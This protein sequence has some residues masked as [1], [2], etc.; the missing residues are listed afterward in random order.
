MR[1]PLRDLNKQHDP[2]QSELNEAFNSVL[3]SG[4]FIEGPQVAQFE[5]A[6]SSRLDRRFAVGVSCGTEALYLGLSALE[7]KRGDS[8]VVTSYS[9]TPSVSC[10]TRLGAHPIFVDIDPHTCNIDVHAAQRAI[11]AAEVMPRA[12]VVVHLFGQSVDMDAIMY[13]AEH[14]EIPVVED[15]AQALGAIY[16]SKY[17]LSQVGS[18]GTLACFSFFPTKPLGVL[19][20]GGM[21]LT[22]IEHVADEVRRLKRHGWDE[23]YVNNRSIGINS[24]LDE[25]QAAFLNVKLPYLDV[26]TEDVRRMAA[27]YIEELRVPGPYPQWGVGSNSWHIYN[28]QLPCMHDRDNM[29][30]RLDEAQ[31]GTEIYFP[32]SLPD[33]DVFGGEGYLYP[34]A[35]RAAQTL[36][37]IPL[38]PGMTDD[39]QS[40]VIER[41]NRESSCNT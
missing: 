15:C 9:L 3:N 25:V 16:P 17:G 31:I 35:N 8:V 18:M 19:G 41:V 32:R 12:I 36:L 10:I 29:K 30:K 20:D 34:N 26:W 39:Q 27:R 22:D 2:I 24:R 33:Q 4:T 13:L 28:L 38:F 23:K 5:H 11:E 37:A 21:V 6:I 1:V 14:Y 7:I 40:F